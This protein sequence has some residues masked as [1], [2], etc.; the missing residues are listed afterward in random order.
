MVRK[1]FNATHL[2]NCE[3]EHL[4]PPSSANVRDAW[5]FTSTVIFLYGVMFRYTNNFTSSYSYILKIRDISVSI[6]LGYGLDDWG[7]RV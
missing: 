4:P 5:S 3:A 2:S 7:S 1:K 6:A